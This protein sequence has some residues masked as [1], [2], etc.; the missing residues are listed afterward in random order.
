MRNVNTTGTGIPYPFNET[1]DSAKYIGFEKAANLS[2]YIQVCI[3][4]CLKRQL[5]FIIQFVV[6]QCINWG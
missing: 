3:D 2:G 6:L 5:Q 1:I 4:S